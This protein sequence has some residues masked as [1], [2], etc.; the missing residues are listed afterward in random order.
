MGRL[1]VRRYRDVFDKRI[2]PRGK[3]YYWLSGEVVEEEAGPGTDIEA[4]R[5]NYISLVPLYF[6]L[7]MGA[8]L[9]HLQAWSRANFGETLYLP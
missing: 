6:D 8:A 1:G 2:D 3:T 4:I 5:N 7:T 9:P